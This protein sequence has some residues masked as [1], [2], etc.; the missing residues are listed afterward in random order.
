MSEGGRGVGERV[1][2][3]GEGSGRGRGVGERGVRRVRVLPVTGS[4]PRNALRVIEKKFGEKVR[5]MY[6]NVDKE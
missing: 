2:R 6:E 3:E 5:E 1:V 4:P